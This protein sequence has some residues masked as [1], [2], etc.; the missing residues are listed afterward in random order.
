M[1]LILVLEFVVRVDLDSVRLEL[2][3]VVQWCMLVAFD[4]CS[5]TLCFCFSL[6]FNIAGR[7]TNLV[8]IHAVD[9]L[10]DPYVLFAVGEA[11]VDWKLRQHQGPLV[12]SST[13]NDDLNPVWNE[14]LTIRAAEDLLHPELHVMLYDSDAQ[15][16]GVINFEDDFLGEVRI[17]LLDDGEVTS[18]LDMLH[19]Y[20]LTGTFFILIFQYTTANKY[21]WWNHCD[22]LTLFF[23]FFFFF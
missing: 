12:K 7:V 5:L 19:E 2:Y 21:V 22:I 13:I 16:G 23:V 10:S 4:S 14:T 18:T 20:P 6:D 17:P 8:G 11:G 9:D 1:Q 15:L 3:F